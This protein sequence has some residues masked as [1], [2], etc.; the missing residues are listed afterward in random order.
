MNTFLGICALTTAI[1][2]SSVLWAGQS[3]LEG[4]AL[5]W[6]AGILLGLTIFWILPEMAE[7]Q[8]WILTLIG[9]SGILVLLA[10]IDRYV[11]PICP[12]CAVGTHSSDPA[13]GSDSCRHAATLGWPVLIFGCIHVFFDGW[14]IGRSEERRVGKECRSRW[15]PY[16]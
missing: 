16:H 2:A 8:G 9:V 1:A 4:R 11:Y 10:W 5:P 13:H 14:T 15:S 3:R 6:T 7:D 12:F